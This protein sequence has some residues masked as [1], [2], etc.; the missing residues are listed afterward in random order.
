MSILANIRSRMIVALFIQAFVTSGRAHDIFKDI[1]NSTHG[2]IDTT[3]LS[4]DCMRGGDTSNLYEW[5]NV[6]MAKHA[7]GDNISQL[8]GLEETFQ[9]SHQPLMVR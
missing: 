1:F 7:A 2:D 8:K 9:V 5:A 3:E 6:S 4:E